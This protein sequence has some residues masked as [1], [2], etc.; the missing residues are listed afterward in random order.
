MIGEVLDVKYVPYQ[1]SVIFAGYCHHPAVLE[2]L[3]MAYPLDTDVDDFFEITEGLP[4]PK[5]EERLIIQQHLLPRGGGGST[6]TGACRVTFC[7][8][9]IPKGQVK[10]SHCNA[11]Y[12]LNKNRGV[13]HKT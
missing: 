9:T 8:W 10:S 7:I 4:L 3:L 2:N 1:A 5:K 12:K 13:Q 6:T 11:V